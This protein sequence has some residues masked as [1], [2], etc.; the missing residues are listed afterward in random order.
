MGV[1]V[2]GGVG[3]WRVMM[4]GVDGVWGDGMWGVMVCG[5]MVCGG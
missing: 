5:V 2:Y 3:V 4:Y 1:K